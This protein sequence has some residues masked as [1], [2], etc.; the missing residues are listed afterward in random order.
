MKRV[1][2]LLVFAFLLVGALTVLAFTNDNYR[3][4]AMLM[5]CLKYNGPV[6][7]TASSIVNSANWSTV[8]GIPNLLCRGG[9]E[10]CAI[11]FDNGTTTPA[12]A[13]F[14]LSEHVR[15]YGA[16]PSHVQTIYDFQARYVTVF[17]DEREE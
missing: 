3:K 5:Q 10:L 2:F 1:K 13:T 8:I 12:Q 4:Q 15:V 16:L 9:W 7:A 17:L 14:I 6:P 11:C